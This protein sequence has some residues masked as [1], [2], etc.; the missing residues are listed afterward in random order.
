MSGPK[1]LMLSVPGKCDEHLSAWG[2][3][4]HG[5]YVDFLSTCR[6]YAQNYN[7]HDLSA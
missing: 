2:G 4:Q 1:L 5:W 3:R 6:K 7:M